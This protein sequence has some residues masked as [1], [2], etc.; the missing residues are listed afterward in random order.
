MKK[1]AIIAGTVVDTDMGANIVSNAGYDCLLYP[2]S[3][4]PQEQ[5]MFQCQNEEYKYLKIKEILKQAMEEGCEKIFVYCNSLSGSVDFRKLARELNIP[6]V[7]PH[8][9][10]EKIAK[11]YNKLGIIAANAQGTA[12]IEKTLLAQNPNLDII[13][14]GYLEIVCDIEEQKN[15]RDIIVVRK[16]LELARF[17]ESTGCEAIV[18]GC[19]HFPYFKETYAQMIDIQLIEPTETMIELLR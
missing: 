2:V 7:T 12:G 11:Q 4:C 8:D 3:K 5:T 6:I 13:T 17:F 19:T 14:V 18:L 16:L 10:Y 1:I 9:V 15:P